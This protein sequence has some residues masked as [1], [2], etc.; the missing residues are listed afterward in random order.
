MRKN[1]LAVIFTVL[2]AFLVSSFAMAW[3]TDKSSTKEFSMISHATVDLESVHLQLY[4]RCLQINPDG[5][6]SFKEAISQWGKKN[7]PAIKELRLI[8]RNQF[9][10]RGIS[11]DDIDKFQSEMTATLKATFANMP[12]EKF[13]T[14]CSAQGAEMLTSQMDFVD[15]LDK[16][17][18]KTPVQKESNLKSWSGPKPEIIMAPAEKE[19]TESTQEVYPFHI[20]GKWGLTG[21]VDKKGRVV[22]EPQFTIIKDFHEDIALFFKTDLLKAGYINKAGKVIVQPQYEWHT[23]FSEGLAAVE[24]NKKW[25]FIGKTGEFVIEPIFSF[26]MTLDHTPSF[27]EGLAAMQNEKKD[28]SWG[29]IDKT[30]KFVIEPHFEKACDFH[31]GLGAVKKNGKWGFIDKTGKFVIEPQFDQNYYRSLLFVD[32]F[33][34]QCPYFS[35]G[36]AVMNKGEKL[37]FIDKTGKFVIE[38]QFEWASDF[39]EG[40]AIV[41]KNDMSGVIDKTGKYISKEYNSIREFSDGMALIAT[42]NEKDWKYG[43]ID[44][45]GRVIVEPIFENEMQNFSEGLV[46]INNN[47][48]WGYIN[49]AGQFIIE[50]QFEGADSFKNGVAGVSKDGRWGLIDKSGKIF[51]INDSVCGH[52][53]VKNGKGEITWPKNIKEL[54]Q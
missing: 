50:P 39:H 34:P 54:C 36:L 27:S 22:I 19:E 45:R 44:N 11:A 5:A 23:N 21:F 43:F 2:V 15:F 28:R 46:A 26:Y 38:P 8:L 52:D 6:K 9:M 35:K 13:Q 49:K 48:K 29:F 40:S 25:G 17:R 16:Y 1:A 53:V 47:G 10:K 3:G 14:I 24:K 30:G 18:T 12:I 20:G 37:G 33:D 51:V 31:E 32:G 42:F 7:Y 4:E 41:R